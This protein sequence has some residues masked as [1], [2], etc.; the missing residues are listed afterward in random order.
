MRDFV[1]TFMDLRLTGD[2][3]R[4]RDYLSPTALEQYGPQL[5]L[6]SKREI[7]ATCD[8]EGEVVWVIGLAARKEFR[9]L[10]LEEPPRLVIDVE[11]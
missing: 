6:T 3:V 7:R 5:P 1:T 4:A 8:F 10:E 9:I 11:R 2:D